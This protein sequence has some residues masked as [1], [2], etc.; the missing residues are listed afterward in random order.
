MA[1]A[2]APPYFI[3]VTSL[4]TVGKKGLQQRIGKTPAWPLPRPR[5]QVRP[6]LLARAWHA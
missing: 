1:L 2:A 6:A 3:Q 5:F 4:A